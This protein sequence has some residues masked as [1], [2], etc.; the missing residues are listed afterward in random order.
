MGKG[1]PICIDIKEQH[2]DL[3]I[4]DQLASLVLAMSDDLVIKEHIYTLGPFIDAY[5]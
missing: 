2:K 3:P 1:S 4:G 5:E